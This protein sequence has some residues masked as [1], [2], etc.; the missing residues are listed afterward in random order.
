MIRFLFLSIFIVPFFAT[1]QL[2]E[3]SITVTDYATKETVPFA[4]VSLN[5]DIK[6]I[7]DVDG[8]ITFSKVAYGEYLLVASMEDTLVKKIKVNQPIT[9]INVSIVV[10]TMSDKG[11]R[12][13]VNA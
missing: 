4:K 5:K 12:M 11:W 1:S 2:S 6:G 10:A 8:K 13:V 3:V 9:S 7:A